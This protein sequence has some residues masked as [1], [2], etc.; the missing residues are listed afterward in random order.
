M[1]DASRMFE[2]VEMIVR[3]LFRSVERSYLEYQAAPQ[4]GPTSTAWRSHLDVLV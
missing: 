1:D 3:I 4:F 2:N